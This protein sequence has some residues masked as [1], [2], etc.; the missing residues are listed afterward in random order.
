MYVAYATKGE[1]LKKSF[2][3]IKT[4]PLFEG[5][6]FIDFEILLNCLSSKTTRYNK[7]DVILLSGNRVD[8]VGL[9]LS[10]GVKIIRDDIDG[11]ITIL[12][13]LS[14]SELFGEV[15]A[16]AGIRHSPVTVQASA[17]CEILFIDYKKI[18]TSCSSSCP[19]HS[20]LIE[21]M[22][23]L[24]AKKNLLLNQKNEI[25][26]KR[27]TREKLL[28]FFDIQRETAKKF[29]IPYDREELAN[30]LCVDRSSLSRELCRMRDDG[31]LSFNRNRFEIY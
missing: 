7:D 9:V 30:Y 31:I 27:T 28:L 26:S 4:N 10:G 17:D 18:I 13:E 29:T 22:L 19:F 3:K 1:V 14:A 25:L 2:E 6:D 16:C 8:F 24:I 5:I 23:K 12:T 21:N 15:F 11:N 20:K